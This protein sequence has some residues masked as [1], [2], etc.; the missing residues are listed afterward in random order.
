MANK[1]FIY[2]I[3]R[4]TA[5]G[6]DA[7]TNDSSGKKLK[8]TKIGRCTDTI[9][10]LYHPKFGGLAN[11][12]SYKPW[13]ENGVQKE[14]ATGTKLTLQDK[15]EQKWGLAKGYLNNKAWMR[16]DSVKSEDLTFYQR[17]TVKLQDGATVLDLDKMEDELAYYLI[18]D[19]KF[20][21]NS[22][23]E[24][25]EHKWP[26]ATHYIALEHEEDELKYSKNQI[27]SAAFASLHSTKLT[28]EIKRK[29]ISILDLASTRV[30]L[31]SA[32]IHN[33]LYSS[34]EKSTFVPGSF[35]EK[36]NEILHLLETATGREEFD[37]RY[38]L[39]QAVD[40]R[41]IYEKQGGYT[42]NRSKGMLVLG[43]TFT[44]AIAF[45]LNPKKAELVEELK[46]EIKAKTL[47]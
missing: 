40:S 46:A 15:L 21:A 38:L 14:D 44:E 9:Q 43:E 1:V 30:T 6:V 31:T 45:L 33:I 24:W 8:K 5:T 23:K 22:E 28:D 3:P 20:I 10:A 13:M 27:R 11:G 25:K 17:F 16:G 37:A 26:K 2:S 18:L 36:Y 29:M 35:I 47:V 32:Q 12:L 41:V 7:W 4:E 19:S 42:W 39:R 34:I